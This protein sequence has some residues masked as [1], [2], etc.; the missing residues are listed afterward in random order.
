MKCK[1]SCCEERSQVVKIDKDQKIAKASFEFCKSSLQVEPTFYQL[2]QASIISFS[3]VDFPKAN[4]PPD[5]GKVPP[6]CP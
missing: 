4:A 2:W 6:L 1:K 5:K 3:V